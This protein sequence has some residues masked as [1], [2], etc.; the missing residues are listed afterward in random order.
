MPQVLEKNIYKFTHQ[1]EKHAEFDLWIWSC[2]E[3]TIGAYQL[4]VKGSVSR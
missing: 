4:Q 2:V 3:I 1:L